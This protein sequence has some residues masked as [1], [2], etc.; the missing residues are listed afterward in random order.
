[1][2][3]KKQIEDAWWT[4]AHIQSHDV[5][6]GS[7]P[8]PVRAEVARWI[9]ETQEAAESVLT[10][11]LGT[12]TAMPAAISAAIPASETCAITLAN[13][14]PWERRDV[15]A[16]ALPTGWRGV[17][18]VRSEDAELAF[19]VRDGA[20]R[21]LAKVP[22]VGRRAC[23]LVRGPEPV[24]EP[25]PAA[26]ESAEIENEFIRVACAADVGIQ[27]IVLLATGEEVATDCG[28]LLVAQHD[29]GRFQVDDPVSGEWPLEWSGVTV[30]RPTTTPLGQRLVMAGVC[31]P[32][33]WAG[34]NSRLEWTV[35]LTLVHG[36]PRLDV[37]V[38]ID[39]VGEASR[40]R[41]RLPTNIDSA[42]GAY[43]IPFGIVNRTPYGVR[44]RANGEWPVHRFVAIQDG[45]HGVALVNTG[46]MG[47]K[48]SAA[49]SMPPSSAR[50][51]RPGS[52]SCRTKPRRNTVA[53][54]ISSLS[55]P[56]RDLLRRARS[57]RA[58]R[59]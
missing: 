46:T 26:V 3:W 58:H 37:R 15:A 57:C 25:A 19:E 2:G 41:L 18:A 42:R 16:I 48:S 20:V 7:F 22:A 43:E 8:H 23:Y 38:Q 49:A 24:A 36:K 32:L 47:P 11:V 35:E 4:M 1:M 9:A 5:Y 33:T 54:R 50:P 31:A 10:R 29:I 14:L 40:I 39:W 52:S 59:R 13:G 12:T 56:M 34:S 45:Q 27:H 44:D 51:P 53:T 30:Y 6:S 28:A 17:S 55:Y 21:I